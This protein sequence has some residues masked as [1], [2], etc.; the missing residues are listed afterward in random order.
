MKKL[1][2]IVF[3]FIHSVFSQEIT[4]QKIQ[5]AIK[6]GTKFLL[7]KQNLNGSWPGHE[8]TYPMGNTSLVILTLI[9]SDVSPEK[10]SIK[11][12]FSYLKKLRFKKTYSAALYLMA[13]EAKYIALSKKLRTKEKKLLKKRNYHPFKLLANRKQQKRAIKATN[14]LATSV[15]DGVWGYPEGA[16]DL[17]NTQYALLGLFASERMGLKINK[18]IYYKVIRN[19]IKSQ[20]KD[21]QKI[22]HPFIVPAADQPIDWKS[23]EKL[24]KKIAQLK[25]K[26]KYA[27]ISKIYPRF[28][29]SN[30][31]MKARGWK[32]RKDH[33]K[34]S[35]SM[36]A[37][38]I[39]CMVISKAY[40][41]KWRK[42][43]WKKLL[44]QINESIRDGCAWIANNFSVKKNPN[45]GSLYY[46]LYGLERAGVLAGIEEF[47]TRNW[48]LEGAKKMLAD[49]KKNGKFGT[50]HSTCF[51]LLFL[52]RATIPVRIKTK[53]NK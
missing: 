11:K 29:K 26:K 18:K 12:A 15:S 52:K 19:F 32:Y 41:E 3:I 43:H 9:K 4:T 14:F 16:G 31:V 2:I 7:S 48:Y 47:G 36:T 49:Q 46:Y 44:P 30:N 34:V 1:L 28:Y 53:L 21:G 39:A 6:K 51:A 35:G 5:N 27:S 38:G 33:G 42:K 45:G 23:R 24:E 17:S 8:D 13:I 20:E 25:R 37:A 40:L 22:N 10:E 50:L